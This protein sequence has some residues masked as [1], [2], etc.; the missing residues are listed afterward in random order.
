MYLGDCLR[1]DVERSTKSHLELAGEGI[2]YSWGGVKCVY[3]RATPAQKKGKGNVRQLVLDCLS[4]K[5]E[6]N[7]GN[8]TPQMVCKFSR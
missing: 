6:S 4:T 2:E 3:H 7:K 5:D 1:V 8:L